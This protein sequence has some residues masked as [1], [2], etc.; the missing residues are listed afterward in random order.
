MARPP[1]LLLLIPDQHRADWMAGGDLPL[2]TPTLQRLAARGV[3]FQRA[4]CTSPLCAP[5]RASLA[6]GRHYAHCGVPGNGH[7]YPLDQPTFYQ[8]LRGTPQWA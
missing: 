5:S 2:R 1:N 4:Y 6:S 3:S 7:N 8:A